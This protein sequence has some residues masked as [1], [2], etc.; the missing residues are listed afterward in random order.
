[1]CEK[2]LYHNDIYMFL[3]AFTMPVQTYQLAFQF[4]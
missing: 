4:S 1:M 3:H 2:I